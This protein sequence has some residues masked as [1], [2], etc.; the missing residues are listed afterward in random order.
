MCYWYIR[1]K[2][3]P[4]VTSRWLYDRATRNHFRERKEHTS[5]H[6]KKFVD[7]CFHSLQKSCLLRV[8]QY[9]CS[10]WLVLSDVTIFLA[11]TNARA[12]P[13]CHIILVSMTFL[14]LNILASCVIDV[15]LHRFDVQCYGRKPNKNQRENKDCINIVRIYIAIVIR[16]ISYI[17]ILYIYK[18]LIC[19]ITA[20]MYS[21]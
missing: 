6:G 4:P 12:A 20:L 3:N 2:F 14:L 21:K 16:L 13:M 19:F 17:D 10:R 18:Q 5:N 8:A 11:Q 15:F 9:T 7:V 1:K